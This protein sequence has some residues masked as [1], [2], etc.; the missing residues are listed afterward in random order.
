MVMKLKVIIGALVILLIGSWIFILSD[1]DKRLRTECNNYIDTE[2]I[3][4]KKEVLESGVKIREVQLTET[5]SQNTNIKRID[6]A[7]PTQ[8]DIELIGKMINLEELNLSYFSSEIDLS[9]LESLTNVKKLS[10]VVAKDAETDTRPLA[11]LQQLEDICIEGEI[12]LSFLEELDNLKKVVMNRNSVI[13]LSIFQHMEKLKQLDIHCVDHADFQDIGRLKKLS[14]INLY[15]Y[16]SMENIEY[17]GYLSNLSSIYIESGVRFDEKT[18][19]LEFLKNLV[20]LR[21]LSI[22]GIELESIEPLS[23]LTSLE[24]LILSDVVNFESKL[25]LEPIGKLENLEY[26][27]LENMKMENLEILKVLKHL[28]RLKIS[29]TDIGKKTREELELYLLYVD[30]E[31]DGVQG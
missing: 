15:I 12:N 1:Y 2:S 11:S 30:I 31:V 28:E 5:V 4:T 16:Q 21:N 9:P 6:C 3:V 17:L 19:N 22:K 29:G 25:N 14:S 23:E 18:V 27:C 8:E 20:S 10:L 26:L 24:N 7:N 13:D